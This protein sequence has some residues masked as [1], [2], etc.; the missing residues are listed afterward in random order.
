MATSNSSAYL[1]YSELKRKYYIVARLNRS[2]PACAPR[3]RDRTAGHCKR[4]HVCLRQC[5]RAP[6]STK[7]H[8][9][10]ID[11]QSG[12]LKFSHA[13]GRDIFDTEVRPPRLRPSGPANGRS[14]PA[15]TAL[16]LGHG[17]QGGRGAQVAQGSRAGV[18]SCMERNLWSNRPPPPPP[19]AA[20][21]AA[22]CRQLLW[23][24]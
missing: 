18:R 20:A 12:M 22:L 13:A 14:C 4:V 3:A 21:R 19:P 6:C 16:Q 24:T 9:I 23:T 7:T 15:D 8:V 17:R 1:C 5:L 10:R 2:D 11:P